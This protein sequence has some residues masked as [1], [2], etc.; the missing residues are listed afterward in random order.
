M[1]WTNDYIGIPYKLHGREMDG[2]DCWGMI[3]QVYRRELRRALPS[4]AE[5]YE[6]TLDGDG[7][8]KSFEEELCKWEPVDTPRE[9]DVAWCRS[10]GVECHTGVILGDG[11]MLHSMMDND[12]CIVRIDNPAW[13][14]RIQQCYRIA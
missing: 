5:N 10:A 14:R 3:C 13:S 8:G 11:K 1:S 2:L 4:Y 7:F 12:S 6:H 9:Y